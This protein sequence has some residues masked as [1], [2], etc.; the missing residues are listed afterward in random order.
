MA[1]KRTGGGKLKRRDHDVDDKTIDRWVRDL[2]KI[3]IGSQVKAL[4]E[5]GEYLIAHVYGSEAEALSRRSNKAASLDRLAE[6]CDEFNLKRAALVR[7]VPFALQVRQLSWPLAG[8]LR[9]GQHR[10]LLVVKDPSEKKLLAEAAVASR[11]TEETLRRKIR[12]I[13]KPHRGGRPPEPAVRVIL[14][15]AQ[16]I[17]GDRAN[18]EIGLEYLSPK[19][20]RHLLQQIGMCR[21][22]LDHLERLLLHHLEE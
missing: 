4:A 12:A 10:Q 11:W 13:Q 21:D 16:P 3:V 5:V 22:H 14:R 18:Y 8:E 9:I 19:E 17:L 6:R 20:A 7:A 15:R 1:K 2:Q